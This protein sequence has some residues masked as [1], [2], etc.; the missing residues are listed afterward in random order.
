MQQHSW[1]IQ[2]RQVQPEAVGKACI[3]S[4]AAAPQFAAA[5]C[6]NEMVYD[7]LLRANVTVVCLT[8]KV[9]ACDCTSGTV[10]RIWPQHCGRDAVSGSAAAAVVL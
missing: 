10:P 2:Q 8:I 7:P 3:Q 6:R 1:Q 4:N 5:C 9:T